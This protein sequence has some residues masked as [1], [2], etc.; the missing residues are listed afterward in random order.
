MSLHYGFSDSGDDNAESGP[1]E[2][3]DADHC[4]NGV[5]CLG[6]HNYSEEY[7]R[8]LWG[9]YDSSQSINK[10]VEKSPDKSVDKSVEKSVE[11]SVDKS[12]EKSVA[13]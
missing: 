1:Y 13:Q 12:V 4:D 3:S 7:N 5:E 8:R 11:K 10:S 6:E 9:I 2:C